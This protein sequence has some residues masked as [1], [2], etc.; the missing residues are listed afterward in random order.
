M[1][2][3]PFDSGDLIAKPWPRSTSRVMRQAG[4][5]LGG[6]DRRRLIALGEGAYSVREVCHILG[7][8]MTPRRVHYWLD[9]GLIF[10]AP[11]IRG[12][13]GVPT[14]LTFRQ[15][16]EIRT[17]QYLR[18]TLKVS[19]RE[20]REAF[21]WILD[22]LFEKG[23]EVKFSR[24]PNGT[25]VAQLDNGEETTVPAGQTLLPFEVRD[26]T[27]TVGATLTA[28]WQKRLPIPQYP[29][30]VTSTSVLGGAPIVSG[31][32]IDT[33]TIAT[34]AEDPRGYTEAD[35]D[36]VLE[37]FPSLK[38]VQIEDAFGFEGLQPLAA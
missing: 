17:V 12:R 24:G 32:R 34:L 35:I 23:R 27:S 9:T 8:S 10:G 22:N 30:L 31:T 19:P 38:I 2:D 33:A 6:M 4:G 15:M 16:L 29:N 1:A 28:W 11:I 13:R 36:A 21:A 37:T 5:M 26:I 20:V 14:I 7:D 25:L 18:D 3:T